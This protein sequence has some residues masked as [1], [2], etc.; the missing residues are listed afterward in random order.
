MRIPY[1]AFNNLS[2]AEKEV[3]LGMRA[4]ND[5]QKATLPLLSMYNVIP[6]GYQLTVLQGLVRRDIMRIS[7]VIMDVLS[8]RGGNKSKDRS[9]ETGA[10]HALPE[11]LQD[12]LLA[13]AKKN[14]RK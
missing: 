4:K 11:K 6:D 12:S 13:V 3:S 5:P 2:A 9:T 14:G 8:Q 1:L 7:N 10:F